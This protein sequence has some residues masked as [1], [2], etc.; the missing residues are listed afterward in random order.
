MHCRPRLCGSPRRSWPPAARR[1]RASRSRPPVP[2]SCAA[3]S[4]PDWCPWPAPPGRL[5]PL[6]APLMTVSFA[7]LAETIEARGAETLGVSL[8]GAPPTTVAR[9]AASLGGRLGAHPAGRCRATRS[10][11]QREK[12]RASWWRASPRKSRSIWRRTSVRAPW[13]SRSP[14]GDRKRRRRGGGAEASAGARTPPAR[15]R[16]R[17]PSAGCGANRGRR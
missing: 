4:S 2:P 13:S 17:C 6:A 3:G 8:R 11:G 1:R 7:A 14:P 10:A 15:L 12:R 9:A 16:G 5:A